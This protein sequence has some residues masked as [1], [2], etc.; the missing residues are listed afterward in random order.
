MKKSQERKFSMYIVVEKGLQVVDPIIIQ[1]VP[2]YRF[3]HES[4]VQYISQIE[5]FRE[6][7]ERNNS[8]T[9]QLKASLREKLTA[10]TLN[11]AR[12][13]TAYAIDEENTELQQV[14]NYT[15]SVLDK[16]ADTILRDRCQIIH[17]T[18]KGE[19][20]NLE[21]YGVTQSM[22]ETLQKDIDKFKEIIPEPRLK[23]T[24]KKD[25]TD[26]LGI[27]FK[28]TDK[29]LKKMD[30]VFEMIREEHPE[31]YRNYKNNRILINPGSQQLPI[32]GTVKDENNNPIP[33]VVITETK[34]GLRMTTGV[35]GT[36]KIKKIEP[37]NYEFFFNK[38]GFQEKRVIVSVNEKETT[39][40][41]V[42][43]Q[44]S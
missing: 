20:E 29:L 13:V 43:M 23:I 4:L 41:N 38:N 27:L 33:N 22:L 37:R 8:G 14:V 35:K 16:S 40:V 32:T 18:A 3:Y 28:N 25:A 24:T 7:Q 19:L 6:K 2:K 39:T 30:K 31:F 9:A 1:I 44:T 15:K 5:T 17:N 21:P 10:S 11:V 26:E 36:F 34:T 42:I 12:K